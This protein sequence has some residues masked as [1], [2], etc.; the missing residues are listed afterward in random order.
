MLLI[1]NILT[2]VERAEIER[3][4]ENQYNRLLRQQQNSQALST[5]KGIT[6]A[7]LGEKN[8]RP[9][10]RFEGN[11]FNYGRKDNRAEEC[12]SMKKKI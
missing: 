4:V 5:S 2:G 7:D 1:E 11:C 12:R 8:R 9:R 3:V 10:N 6:T